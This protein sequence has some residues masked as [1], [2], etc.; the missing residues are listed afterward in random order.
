MLFISNTAF[1]ITT[2]INEYP[3]SSIERQLLNKMSTSTEKYQYDNLNQLKFELSLRKEI[4]GTAIS[5]NNSGLAFADFKYSKCNSKYWVRTDNGGFLLNISAEPSEAIN[6]IYTNGDKYAAECA[7]AI[8]IIYYRAL[9]NIYGSK[10]FNKVFYK[11]YLMD[12]VVTEPLL[13]DVST[14]RSTADILL[15][16]R[17]YFN[18]PDFNPATPEWQGENVIVLPD[19]LYY[20]HGIGITTADMIIQDLNSRRRE[21][22]AWSAYIL[23]SAGRPNFK[24]L[25]TNYQS[26]SSR[27][28]PLVWKPFPAPILEYESFNYR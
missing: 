16:D 9:L 12:W 7:T 14:L 13:E 18:N 23:N 19:S 1:N 4:V 15:G 26:V 25:F 5:L 22:A 21:N 28:E 27:P 17:G 8:M 3:K 10:L 24:K 6:D 2:I 11:I 20:G